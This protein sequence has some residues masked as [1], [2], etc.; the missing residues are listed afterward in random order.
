VHQTEFQT[1]ELMHTRS[2]Y[3]HFPLFLTIAIAGVVAPGECDDI[4]PRLLHGPA[5]WRLRLHQEPRGE[6]DGLAN[7][8]PQGP[9]QPLLG[10]GQVEHLL[11]CDPLKLLRRAAGDAVPGLGGPQVVVVDAGK[12]G[13]LGKVRW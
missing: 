12:G 3:R 5:H 10:E 2:R 11:G 13:G 9:R 6:H 8:Q 1:P 4:L 7:Q